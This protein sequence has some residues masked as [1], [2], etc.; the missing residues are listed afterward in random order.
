MTTIYFC[1]HGE[2]TGNANFTFQGCTDNPLTENGRKQCQLLAQRLKDTHLDCIYTSPLCRAWETGKIINQFHNVRVIP[3]SAF[4]EISCGAIEGYDM[5]DLHDDFPE[6]MYQWDHEPWNFKAPMGDD[7]AAKRFEA[8]GIALRRLTENHPGQTVLI[9]SHGGELRHFNCIA[10]GLDITH[11]GE[12]GW[13]DNTCLSCA[14]FELVDGRLRGRLVMKN[15]ASHVDKSM[16]TPD[17]WL[18]RDELKAQR[19]ARRAAEGG[20]K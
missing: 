18:I 1:R 12:M 20:T 7:S 15:D 14:E 10:Q 3:D 4:Q 2:T 5:L 9:A 11:I 16:I 6:A 17:F 19:D 13:G 8:M